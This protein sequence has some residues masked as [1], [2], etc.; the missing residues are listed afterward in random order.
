MK[1]VTRTITVTTVEMDVYKDGIMSRAI[2]KFY[3]QPKLR[4]DNLLGKVIGEHGR[5]CNIVTMSTEEVLYSISV[6]DF[7]KYG[8]VVKNG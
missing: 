1:K 2:V 7:V 3:E 6:E 5:C 8:E 4:H